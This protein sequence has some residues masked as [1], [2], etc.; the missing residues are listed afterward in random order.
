MI[1]SGFWNITSGRNRFY[2]TIIITQTA[3]VIVVPLFFYTSIGRLAKSGYTY[4]GQTS[5]KL[6]DVKARDKNM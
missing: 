6:Y 4:R 5:A 1:L 3:Y 2:F